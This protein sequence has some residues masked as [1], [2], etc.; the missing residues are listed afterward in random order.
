MRVLVVGANG[1][2]GT[3]VVRN[4]VAGLHDPVAMIRHPEQRSAFD[5]LGVNTVLGDLEYPI[6]HAVMG[7][8]ALIFAAGSGGSTGKDK[9]VLV[10]R[11]GAI[12]TMVAAQVHGVNR[13]IMLSATYVDV[14]SRSPIAHYHQ[15]KAHADN[16][17]RETELS[18]TIVCPGRLTDDRGTGRVSVDPNINLA[19]ETSRDNLA[20]ALAMCLD[21]E[22]TVGKTFSLLEGTTEIEHALGSV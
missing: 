17:L 4:L 5:E 21:M 3:R 19:G 8:D 22:N 11:L 1:K 13:Y 6:D 18:Y 20:T 14:Q 10:D 7:C 2:T 9:T 12:R 16:Y 15:A